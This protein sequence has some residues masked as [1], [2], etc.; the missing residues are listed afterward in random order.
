VLCATS[1]GEEPHL[2]QPLVDS[3]RFSAD[4][5]HMRW[6]GAVLG[7]GGEAAVGGVTGGAWAAAQG[8]R[9]GGGGW[10]RN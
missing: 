5:M 3:L 8:R 6:G 4:Y 1:S 9:S 10:V 2:A 7:G